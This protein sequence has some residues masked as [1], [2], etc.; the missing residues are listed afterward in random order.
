MRPQRRRVLPC[1][2]RSRGD[3]DRPCRLA[4]DVG[5]PEQVAERIAR[6]LTPAQIADDLKIAHST[7]LSYLE[8]AVGKGLV[9]RSDIYFTLRRGT[10]RSPMTREDQQVVIRFGS[11]AHATGDMYEDLRDIETT[12]HGRIRSALEKRYGMERK[13]WWLQLPLGTR[14]KCN[15]RCEEDSLSL[16]PYCYTDLLDLRKIVD[17]NWSVLQT[18]MGG[19]SSDKPRLM[20]ELVK[21][22][23]IRNMVMHPARGTRPTEADFQFIRDLRRDLQL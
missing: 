9:R 14:N 12:L 3:H 8:T 13:D 17:K 20:S 2:V 6:G 15:E 19:F 5:R 4:A 11:A 21:L 7:T 23:R 22:N 18:E 16:D 10:R 1:G